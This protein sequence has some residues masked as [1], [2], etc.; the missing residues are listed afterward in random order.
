MYGGLIP[1]ELTVYGGAEHSR[2]AAIAQEDWGTSAG[3]SMIQVNRLGQRVVN[4]KINGDCH[5]EHQARDPRTADRPNR[6]TFQIH[7]QRTADLF[8]H[9]A[10]APHILRAESMAELADGLRR[11]LR[12]VR[13]Y[14]DELTLDD[15]FESGL[16]TSIQRFNRFARNGADE[17]F[18]RGTSA[19]DRNNHYGAH[20]RL[21]LARCTQAGRTQ[22]ECLTEFRERVIPSLNNPYP[23]PTMHPIG[24]HGPYYGIIIGPNPVDTAGGPEVDEIGRVQA[25]DGGVIPRL[26]GAG[27]CVNGPS[28]GGYWGGG[29]AIGLAMAT[30]WLAGQA[31][32]Q[33][34]P[35]SVEAAFGSD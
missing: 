6:L 12:A 26:F 24:E 25:L 22:A 13:D 1:F 28:N 29:M 31:A 3:D 4:E 18:G 27:S 11:R 21:H 33:A 15:S 9:T 19:M 20:W 16:A 2:A 23:D 30:G 35:L 32:V 14:T 17:D 5:V 7:D 34:T 8:P 10:E